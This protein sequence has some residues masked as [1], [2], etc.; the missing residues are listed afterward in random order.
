MGVG[1]RSK[2]KRMMWWTSILRVIRS[3]YRE[4]RTWRT[5][6]LPLDLCAVN[7][8]MVMWMEAADVSARQM[9]AVD[10]DDELSVVL[11]ATEA[12]P[13]LSVRDGR[14]VDAKASPAS[15]LGCCCCWAC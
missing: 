13:G 14:V 5:L 8:L 15:R 4:P 2:L 1:V 11:R 6:T 7:L 12:P 3:I 10:V 9:S